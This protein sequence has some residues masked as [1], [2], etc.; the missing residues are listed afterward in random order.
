MD[1]PANNDDVEIALLGIHTYLRVIIKK[2]KILCYSVFMD[3][4]ENNNDDDDDNDDG[5]VIL[6]SLRERAVVRLSKSIGK[7][8]K[9]V[10]RY[11]LEA[12]VFQKR[13]F[14]CP[15]RAALLVRP[16]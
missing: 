11:L 6:Y 3:E 7:I 9:A 14:G 4:P 10:R 5:E 1:N 8:V 13:V 15:F 12:V 2:K 16:R